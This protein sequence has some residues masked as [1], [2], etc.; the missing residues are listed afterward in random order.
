[1]DMRLKPEQ[2][3]FNSLD[4]DTK[5]DFVLILIL[6]AS[7]SV[8]ELFLISFLPFELQT[9]YFFIVNYLIHTGNSA[10]MFVSFFSYT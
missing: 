8:N 10:S 1:M 4:L 3:C 7:Q 6:C 9:A 2:S 5:P